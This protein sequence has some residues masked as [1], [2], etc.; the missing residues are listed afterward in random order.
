MA[1]IGPSYQAGTLAGNPLAARAGLALLDVLRQENP[2]P[3]M[4]RLG[5]LLHEGLVEQASRHGIPVSLNRLG[6]MFTLFFTE[7]VVRDY[8]GALRSDAKRFARFY[9]ALLAGGVYLAPS[10]LECWFVSA[11]HT[12]RE[13]ART[14]EVSEQAFAAL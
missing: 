9:H 14:L 10:R 13:I 3:E 5:K 11:V 12:E 7:G 6:G 8:D 1:P 4:E 2:Y